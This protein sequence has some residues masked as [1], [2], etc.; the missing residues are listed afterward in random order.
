MRACRCLI[1]RGNNLAPRAV[2]LLALS[3]WL[4]AAPSAASDQAP[5][6]EPIAIAAPGPQ[7]VLGER[8]SFHGRWMGLPV[9]Y[10]WLH[11]KELLTIRGRQ[12]YHIEIQGHTNDVLSAFYP[13][14][15]EVHSYLD[16]KTLRPVRFEK[17]QR[18]GRYRAAEVVD[19]DW[20]THTAHYR[21]L[22]N[23]SVKEV[24]IPDGMH[25]LISTLYW[26]RAQA[27]AP[28]T[29]H[30]VNIYTDEKVYETEVRIKG[31]ERLELL[32]RGTFPC[33]VV[34][35]KTSFKGLMV[36]RGRIWA[37]LTADARRLPLLVK[38]TTP[39]GQMSAVLDESS[40][41]ASGSASSVP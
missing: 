39:W 40:I 6:E 9:G 23:G 27:L 1:T 15:D 18:E 21:S 32:K 20:D 22:L 19:F 8:L 10:G 34:E 30:T 7:P 16:A 29:S 2:V 38:A 13:I 14:H 31:V 35:P 24:P 12:V 25:D 11:V 4:A 41:A 36:K 3:L 37:Y 33:L 17:V 28:Q 5:P 26:V